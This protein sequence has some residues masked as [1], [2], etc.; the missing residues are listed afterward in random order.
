[1]AVRRGV[2]V[3]GDRGLLPAAARPARRGR[4][5]DAV[6]D[7]GA[8]RPARGARARRALRA[9]SSRSVRRDTHEQDAAGLRAGGYEQLAARGR[10]LRGA[11]TSAALATPASAAAATCSARSRAH[12]QWTSSATHAVLPLLATDAGVRM[13]VQTGIDA[14]RRRFGGDWRRRLLAARVRVRAVARARARGRRRRAPCA[15]S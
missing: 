14:H 13:Q 10:A 7:A 12:A 1:M 5:A 8:V 11:T 15:S 4:A 9:R 6:A 3:G 2:A